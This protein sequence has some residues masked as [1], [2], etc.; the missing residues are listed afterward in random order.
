MVLFMGFATT[1][2]QVTAVLVSAGFVVVQV[3]LL[4]AALA[5]H[6][7]LRAEERVGGAWAAGIAAPMMYAF[8][9]FGVARGTTLMTEQ[10]RRGAQESERAEREAMRTLRDCLLRHA[11]THPEQGFPAT[12]DALGP[13][14]AACR[15]ADR[16]GGDERYRVTYLPGIADAQGVVR[17]FSLCAEPRRYGS[18]GYT[19]F[20]VD[21]S[22]TS[23][24]SYPTDARD[25]AALGCAAAWH[26]Q[27]GMLRAVKHCLVRHAARD[28]AHGYPATLAPLATDGCLALESLRVADDGASSF[29]SWDEAYLYVPGPADGDG[30]IRTFELRQRSRSG[31]R[32]TLIDET[33]AVHVAEEREA[34]RADPPPEVGEERRC[35]AA[36]DGHA[37]LT[38]AWKL[39]TG[40]GVRADPA[41]ALELYE[42]ACGRDDV[43]ACLG[44]GS[45]FERV[46][47]LAAAPQR[48]LAL[49]ERACTLGDVNGCE[50]RKLA[51]AGNVGSP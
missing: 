13:A 37:C 12:L 24:E 23:A 20:V 36:G 6:R 29:W 8:L 9:W 1:R 46:P 39:E 38:L 42:L 11:D 14:G 21:E 3:L 40:Q 10:R 18:T 25:E 31:A 50:Q 26:A 22:G 4:G 32:S 43:Q 34:T 41:R 19:T 5:V 16:A 2:E 47:A 17:L 48:R 33:G 28:P 44:G 27:G 7:G 45:L 49:F 30:R 15:A 51:A 35:R